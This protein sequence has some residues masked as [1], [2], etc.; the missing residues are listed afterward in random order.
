[1]SNC[2]DNTNVTPCT[3]KTSFIVTCDVLLMSLQQQTRTLTTTFI[4][5]FYNITRKS[6]FVFHKFKMPFRNYWGGQSWSLW[7][8]QCSDIQTPQIHWSGEV[9]RG[10]TGRGHTSTQEQHQWCNAFIRFV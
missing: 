10:H 3:W 7:S 4:R 8:W 1:M 9:S 5:S 6:Q 2:S